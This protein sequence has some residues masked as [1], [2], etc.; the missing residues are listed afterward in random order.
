MPLTAAFAPLVG[1]TAR[2]MSWSPLAGAGVV[3]AVLFIVMTRPRTAGADDVVRALRLAGIVLATGA[4][5]VL[6]DPCAGTLAASP[7]RLRA[8]SLVRL[9]VWLPAAGLAWFGLC[10][11]AATAPALREPLAWGRLTF[12]TV[13]LAAFG[14]AASAVAARLD[15]QQRGSLAVAPA[16]LG[17]AWLTVVLPEPLR[18]W[19]D[20][21][22]PLA[23]PSSL[24]EWAIVLTVAVAALALTSRDPGRQ[25]WHSHGRAIAANRSRALVTV[26]RSPP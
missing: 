5:G 20:P 12:E 24:R 13:T 9:C 11:A 16:V 17:F 25:P 22:D 10:V 23:A 14:L 15:P 19:T 4:A 3:G 21:Y 6:D 7:I 18:P 1:P 26:P 8:R 2:A